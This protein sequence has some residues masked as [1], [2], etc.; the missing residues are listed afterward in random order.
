MRVIL[1]HEA[2]Q[3]A[4]ER[5][6][7]T[8]VGRDQDDCPFADFPYGKQG[9]LE[10]D[11]TRGR[12]A[13]D[14]VEQPHERPHLDGRLLGLAHLRGRDH[15][16][17]PGDLRRAADRSD[18]PTKLTSARH[19]SRP[20]LLEL[21]GGGLQ[22]RRQRF[23]ECLLLRDLSEQIGLGRRQVL[24]QPGLVVLQAVHGDQVH[25][26][27]LNDPE[28]GHLDVDRNRAVLGL[29]EQLDD[30]LPAIDLCLRRRVQ[31]GAELRE[32]RQ[33]PK[34]REIALET[35][36]DLLHGFELRRGTDARYRNADRD[37][38]TCALIEQVGFQEDLP[39]GDR[40][41]VGGDVCRY[42][43]GLRF[44]DGQGRE[45]T[46][47]VLLPDAGGAFQQ[48]AVEVE[49]VSRIRFA[50]GRPL[51]HEGY[52][53]VRHGVLG[54]V[55]VDDERVHG[56]VHE[57]F[58]DGCPRKRRQI[59][60]RG[61]MGGGRGDDDG[62]GHRSRFLEDGDEARDRRLLL[63]DGDV[64]AVEGTI[65]LVARG[66]R[67]AIQARLADDRIDADR[68]LAGRAVADDQLALTPT[69]RD[70]RVD[71]HDA[72]LDGLADRTAP[73]DARS[74]LLD[75]IGDVARD[76][77]LAVQRLPEHVHDPAQQPLADRHL[78][79]LAGRAYLVAL[80]E[81][82][83][84]AE[85][86][87]ADVGLVETQ[88]ESGDAVAEVEHL[89]EH[90]IGQTLDTGDAVADLTNDPDILS[91]G[92]DP[93]VGNARFDLLHQAAHWFTSTH[94]A[95]GSKARLERGQAAFDAAVVDIA[96]DLEAHPRD[97]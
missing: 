22:L 63:A 77:S 86:D 88:R 28:Q 33:L 27:V 31:L 76:R 69:Y 96:A 43:A 59:L 26:P 79:Q 13:L 42:V 19:G 78:E 45:R 56:V 54:Q 5:A 74:D 20:D 49:H 89:V 61:G 67:G 38:G 66:F 40:D 91:D 82:G 70:H 71:C 84:V 1:S 41:D 53:A 16:H 80:F 12:L 8:L 6:A 83:I 50:T 97:Q 60:A 14:P 90:D 29:V 46:V 64:D 24:G 15:L 11:R 44:D 52:L 39:V 3:V 7:Q 10:V 9:V 17:G 51:Q 25:V 30:A 36:S 93:R 37:R 48:P 55:V 21:V 87:D 73:H 94:P 95:P 34:L 23:A 58:A 35:A 57:P 18:A 81:L 75:R 32:R 2:K 47:A 72:G 4:V 92:D 65:V 68:R 62:V 85:N